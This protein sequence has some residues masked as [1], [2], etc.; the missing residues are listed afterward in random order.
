MRSIRPKRH[1][2]ENCGASE[3]KFPDLPEFKIPEPTPDKPVM[4]IE[5]YWEWNLGFIRELHR[6]GLYEE[7]RKHSPCPVEAR[8]VWHKAEATGNAES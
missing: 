1:I 7:F 3:L 2:L 6:Q 8:F 4:T 5:Q